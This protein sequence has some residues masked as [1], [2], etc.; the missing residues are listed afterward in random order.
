MIALSVGLATLAL[1]SFLGAGPSLALLG[2]RARP[3]WPLVAPV[4]GFALVVV[5]SDLPSWWLPVPSYAWPLFALLAA[6]SLGLLLRH[7]RAFS[8]RALSWFLLP[9][10]LLPWALAPYLRTGWLTTL[11]EHN[12]DWICY[13]DLETALA[14]GGYGA[15]WTDTGDLFADMSA[16]LRRG[17]WRAGL[18]IA[19]AW[20]SGLSGFA[21]HQ[22]DGALW[23]VLH[24][25]L[26]GAVL[27]AHQLLV[28]RASRRARAF[29]LVSAAASGP[30]LLLLRM[31]FASHLAAMPLLVVAL[32]VAW[33][34]L[35]STG[36][37]LRALAALLLA[38]CITVLADASPYLAAMG[39][40]L[41]LAARYGRDVSWE[42]LRA[43]AYW[44]VLAPA[45]VPAAIY[46]I[47][48]SVRSLA[49]TG[50]HAPAA[51]FDASLGLLA[52]TSFGDHV[53]EV[54]WTEEPW[55]LAALVILGAGVGAAGLAYVSRARA[56][57]TRAALLAPLGVAATLMLGCDL[58][59]LDYP[60]W[61][62][63]LT[64]SPLVTLALAAALDRARRVGVVAGAILLATQ[65]AT[66]AWATVR[67]PDPIGVLPMHEA[68]AAR[69]RDMPGRLHLMGHQG[70]VEGVGHEHALAYLFAQQRR[71]LHA[72]AHPASYYRV[73]WPAQDH[74]VPARG[75]PLRV[76][77][78]DPDRV[79]HAG[80]AL[81]R[82]G[83]F[84]VFAP[85]PGARVSSV[86]FDEGF[87][88][89]EREPERLFRWADAHAALTVDL[90]AADACLAAEL[91]GTPDG[92]AEGVRIRIRPFLRE[93][94]TPAPNA[95][96]G[97]TIVPLDHDWTPR[98]IGWSGGR[99][100]TVRIEFDYL[101][102]RRAEHVDGR[103]IHMAFGNL[104]V[105]RGQACPS[106]DAP[107]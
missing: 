32:P 44:A 99:P 107:P 88:G 5:A 56:R 7:R 3:L 96:L 70:F 55:P 74:A 66:V 47:V 20:L 105:R 49:V 41:V 43:R 64:A 106:N 91:R 59:H 104:S 98:T 69:L 30:A 15:S 73:S 26:P 16:V 58:L 67:A 52:A 33:R 89:P 4:V 63:A 92:D 6:T 11:S 103:P 34:G 24:A 25:C 31:S 46:R 9:A 102:Q 85:A 38:A 2:P 53:H 19:S 23:G 90:P 21:P 35:T 75:E 78:T 100:Q 79:L 83:P 86:S 14:R 18:S 51:R 50:Y 93:T 71:T 54:R 76:I 60:T 87:L 42:R 72:V 61:K 62:I 39:V 101:G 12:H 95:L 57:A 97:E 68:L 65:I 81:F 77:T 45:L 37:T 82:S 28:P 27:A 13:L 10:L 84:T 17:G 29:V 40:G 48:L 80:R 36:S 94:W 1:F 8:P 22:V